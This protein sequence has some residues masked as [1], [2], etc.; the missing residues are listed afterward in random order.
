[1]NLN[2][3]LTRRKRAVLFY[4]AIVLLLQTIAPAFHGA[5]AQSARGYTDIVCTMYGPVEVFVE[6]E[7]ESEDRKQSCDECTRCILQANLNAAAVDAEYL[8][9]ARFRPAPAA[10]TAAIDTVANP[11][12]YPSFLSRAPPL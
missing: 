10:K 9:D 2:F 11:A 1:M 7:T 3:T 5:M 12:F 4:S 8:P 6:L